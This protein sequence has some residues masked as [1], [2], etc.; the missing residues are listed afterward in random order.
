[1]PTRQVTDADRKRIIAMRI[2]A[3]EGERLLLRELQAELGLTKH[4]VTLVERK[5]RDRR[6]LGTGTAERRSRRP[7]RAWEKEHGK[8]PP[9]LV[10]GGRKA[11][12]E[13][14]DRMRSK[15]ADIIW[16]NIEVLE[17]QLEANRGRD[18]ITARE[19]KE[20]TSTIGI[21]VEKLAE[22][23]KQALQANAAAPG[24]G[25]KVRNFATCPKELLPVYRRIAKDL[26][27]ADAQWDVVWEPG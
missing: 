25:R 19:G 5:E 14:R 6:G 20:L 24:G 17:K 4:Q 16:G 18:T 10:T 15:M 13:L 21:L 26:R 22:L 23:D 3:P 27:D 1:M 12:H 9:D 8:R 11:V 2:D 7:K